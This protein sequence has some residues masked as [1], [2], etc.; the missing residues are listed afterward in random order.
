M[1]RRENQY[2]RSPFAGL[3]GLVFFLLIM[4]VLFKMV[5]GAISIIWGIMAFVAP[6]L[7]IVSMFLN[8]NVI[9]NYGAKLFDTLKN[10]TVRGLFYTLATIIGYPVVSAYLFY[11]AFTTR[12]QINKEKKKTKNKKSDEDYVKFEEVEEDE[13]FLILPEIDDT[14]VEEEPQK[15]PLNRYDD[16]FKE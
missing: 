16:L 6:L 14:P 10:D 9:K 8:F 11:K 4:Y 7:I 5:F 13:D 2:S 15:E 12:Q 3:L 1:A